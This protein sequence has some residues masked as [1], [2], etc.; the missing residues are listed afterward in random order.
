MLVSVCY[1][2]FPRTLGLS[3]VFGRIFPLGLPFLG[4]GHQ[5]REAH[6]VFPVA[7]SAEGCLGTSSVFSRLLPIPYGGYGYL[8]IIPVVGR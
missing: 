8:A 6:L 7:G 4:P 5:V 2:L 1:P 3:P